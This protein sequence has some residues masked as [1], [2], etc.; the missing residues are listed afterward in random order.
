LENP[1][2]AAHLE[3]TFKASREKNPALHSE[4]VGREGADLVVRGGFPAK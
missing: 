3:K 4:T 2:E 1:G